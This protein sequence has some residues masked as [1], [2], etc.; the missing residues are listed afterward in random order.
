MQESVQ[1][2]RQRGRLK[3]EE[4]GHGIGVVYLGTKSSFDRA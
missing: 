1:A 3:W 4:I 2:A